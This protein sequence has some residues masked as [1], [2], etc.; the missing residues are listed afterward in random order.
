M[1]NYQ[2]IRD[3]REDNDKS[4]KEIAAYLGVVR[5]GYHRYETGKREMPV[6]YY[7]KLATLYKVS[8][9]YL[10]GLTDDPS[11]RWK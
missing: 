2:R 10:L 1:T 3:L 11:P 4:Q 5:E 7:I 9:D 6:K 8:V